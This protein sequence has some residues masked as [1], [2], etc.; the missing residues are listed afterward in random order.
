MNYNS[1][2]Y[3]HCQQHFSQKFSK[4][5]LIYIQACFS[6]WFGKLATLYLKGSNFL[7][8]PYFLPVISDAAQEGSMESIPYHLGVL[9]QLLSHKISK[10]CCWYLSNIVKFV[11]ALEKT[12][13]PVV[14][15]YQIWNSITT[16]FTND[17]WWLGITISNQKI[18]IATIWMIF[19]HE[20]IEFHF[21][22]RF[23]IRNIDRPNA[24]SISGVF[25]GIPWGCNCSCGICQSSTTS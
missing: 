11:F 7:F 4:T 13:N 23:R 16:E 20:R 10:Q 19:K 5:F 21:D 8:L 17:W 22:Y 15:P 6:I 14:L 12:L 1:G 18:I 3:C 9:A 24:C 25:L 2:Y